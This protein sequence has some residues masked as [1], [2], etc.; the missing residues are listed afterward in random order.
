MFLINSIVA[1]NIF[2]LY[3]MQSNFTDMNALNHTKCD[4]SSC[5]TLPINRRISYSYVKFLAEE[6]E[7]SISIETTKIPD[8][9]SIIFNTFFSTGHETIKQKET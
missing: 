6:K 1:R 7:K 9:F 5:P 4:S 2:L 8:W 3:I